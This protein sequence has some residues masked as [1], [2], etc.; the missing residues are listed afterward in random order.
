MPLSE[1]DIHRMRAAKSVVFE[2][3]DGANSIVCHGGSAWARLRNGGD[4]RPHRI[5]LNRADRKSGRLARLALRATRRIVLTAP[6]QNEEWLAALRRARP[7]DDLRCRWEQRRRSR[8]VVL[9]LI[10]PEVGSCPFVIVGDE[11]SVPRH[12]RHRRAL[13]AVAAL[14]AAG[15]VLRDELIRLETLAALV[16]VGALLWWAG[17]VARRRI[18]AKAQPLLRVLNLAGIVPLVVAVGTEIARQHGT[19]AG[20]ATG[21][22]FRRHA[23]NGGRRPQVLAIEPVAHAGPRVPES[24]ESHVAATAQVLDLIRPGWAEGIPEAELVAA[25]DPG[26]VVLSRAFGDFDDG[27]Q[28]LLGFAQDN[29]RSDRSDCLRATVDVGDLCDHLADIHEA[30]ERTAQAWRKEI[31]ARRHAE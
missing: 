6:R 30:A 3:V 21:G 13:V 2:E 27:L 7:G 4:D 26:S 19:E 17:S 25:N 20:F 16:L 31:E 22:R 1:Q 23:R 11:T 9:T 12:R 8:V 18:R 28:A 15:W 10:R 24:P 29:E 5:S 14:A